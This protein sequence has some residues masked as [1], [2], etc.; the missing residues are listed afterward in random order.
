MRDVKLRT[1]LAVAAHALAAISSVRATPTVDFET[2]VVLHLQAVT[3]AQDRTSST[4]V[5]RD[6]E[7][8]PSK[9]TAFALS[10]PWGPGKSQ[11]SVNLTA[12]LLSV[13]P[14]GEAVLMLESEAR[15]AGGPPL[16]ASRELRLA[17]EGSGLFEIFG[18]KDRRLLLAIRG[19]KV[20]R[21]VVRPPAVVGAPVRFTVAIERVLGDRSVLLETN[22]LHTFVGQSVEYSFRSGQGESLETVR[23]ALLP[24]AIS[25]DIMTIDASISGALPGASGT[26][27]LSRNERIAASR[28][29][30]SPIAATAGT[31]PAGYR[32]QVTPDF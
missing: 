8:G 28:Q 32:F 21:A 31:P 4:G 6:G 24:S 23:L 18:E 17:E 25:G 20:R 15:N 30:I 5:S 9:A 26:V 1:P 22:E 14:E 2:R 16:T 3:V 29:S 19:E 13:T 10:V 12:K 7:V 11:V 27:L